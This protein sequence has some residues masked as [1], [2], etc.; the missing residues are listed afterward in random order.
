MKIT[1]HLANN[2]KVFQLAM[3][4]VCTFQLL[5]NSFILK[6][7]ILF[8]CLAYYKKVNVASEKK[9]KNRIEMEI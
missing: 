2:N 8:T 7:C 6:S 9:E 3:Q 5:L 4:A 1:V